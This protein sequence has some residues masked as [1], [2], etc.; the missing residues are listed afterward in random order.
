MTFTDEYLGIRTLDCE[1]TIPSFKRLFTGYVK[2]GHRKISTLSG[3]WRIQCEHFKAVAF[4]HGLDGLVSN[5]WSMA[6][7]QFPSLNIQTGP[8]DSLHLC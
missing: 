2:E 4:D 1:P 6:Q 5:G 8:L 3:G 7:G